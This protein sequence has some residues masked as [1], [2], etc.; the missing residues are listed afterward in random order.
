MDGTRVAFALI[1][2][3]ALGLA[4]SR[5]AAQMAPDSAVACIS[6]GRLFSFLDA[7]DGN[8]AGKMKQLLKGDCRA[9]GS[10]TYAL[11]TNRNGTAKILVFKRPGDWESAVTMYTLDELLRSHHDSSLDDP[12]SLS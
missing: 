2:M 1:A 5:V 4:S 11:V 8:D 6:E 3:L 12:R 7:R 9:L 10:A